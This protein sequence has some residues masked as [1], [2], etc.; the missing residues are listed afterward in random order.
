MRQYLPSSS[1]ASATLLLAT[2]VSA[3]GSDKAEDDEQIKIGFLYSTEGFFG[4]FEPSYVDA[5]RLAAE[6]INDQGG[7]LNRD[8]AIKTK[9]FAGKLDEVEGLAQELLDDGAVAVIGP[10][11]PPYADRIGDLP[12]E[13][14]TP[15]F[16]L[17]SDL[18]SSG[19]GY[20]MNLLATPADQ[21]AMV[22]QRAI[23]AKQM[24]MAV[25]YEASLTGG[26]KALK[27]EF[28]ARGGTIT[29]SF[30]LAPTDAADDVLAKIMEDPPDA[31]A[32]VATPGLG[33]GVLNRFLQTYSSSSVFWR[34]WSTLCTSDFP[35]GV[36]G[37][38]VLNHEIV[39][40]SFKAG[41]SAAAFAQAYAKRF[42]SNVVAGNPAFDAVFAVALA[43]AAAGEADGAKVRAQL[44]KVTRGGKRYDYRAYAEARAAI[45][46]G[47]DVDFAGA[48][49]SFDYT[50]DG[51]L[52]PGSVAFVSCNFTND[53]KQ[54]FGSEPFTLDD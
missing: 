37:V 10:L 45:A 19:A 40:T 50:D 51:K 36:P 2:L 25:I 41:V 6:I 23:E 7:S 26:A 22:A 48:S 35:V 11:V 34:L 30:E 4:A 44:P 49:H 28:E 15:F 32:L 8:V 9:N 46:A 14:E 1:T 20:T 16:V 54:V 12:E 17:T 13:S 24:S 33:A 3:C 52:A 53:G 27:Q 38:E 18:L 31:I 47:K 42:P 21:S 5:A 43:A 29:G 39:S